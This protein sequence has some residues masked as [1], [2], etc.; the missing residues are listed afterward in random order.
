MTLVL[1]VNRPGQLNFFDFFEIPDLENVRNDT[2][3]ES[4]AFLQPEIR[5]VTRMYV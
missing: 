5:K 2:K 4:I 3:F 1:K